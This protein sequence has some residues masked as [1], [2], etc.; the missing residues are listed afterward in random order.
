ML[1]E[2][3]YTD[4]VLLAHPEATLPADCTMEALPPVGIICDV[5]PP[6]RPP[7]VVD[8]VREPELDRTEPISLVITEAA[9]YLPAPAPGTPGRPAGRGRITLDVIT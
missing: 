9:M 2:I 1:I 5:Q 8:G 3:S 4:E 6:R 7:A